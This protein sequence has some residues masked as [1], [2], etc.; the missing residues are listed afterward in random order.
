[1]VLVVVPPSEFGDESLRY[2][3]SSL[4]NVHVGTRSVSTRADG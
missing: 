3:R 2:A 4:S 1:M